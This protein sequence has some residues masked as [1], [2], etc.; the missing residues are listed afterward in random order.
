LADADPDVVLDLWGRQ[1]ELERSG[2]EE[3]RARYEAQ[4][5]AAVAGGV[6]AGGS[7]VME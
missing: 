4:M 6:G 3:A 2:L 7:P 5:V 1:I